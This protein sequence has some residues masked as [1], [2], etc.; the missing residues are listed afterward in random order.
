MSSQVPPLDQVS[1]YPLGLVDDR[2]LT[3][4]KFA[5][6]AGISLVTLRRRIAAHDGPIVTKLSRTSFGHSRA[7]CTGM[8]GRA[9][10]WQ[11]AG[12]VIDA[13][14]SETPQQWLWAGRG[15]STT[16]ILIRV[17][18]VGRGR[19]SA[20]LADGGQVIVRSS[21]QPFLDAA[22]RLIDLGYEPTTVL[23]MR[24]AGSDID[25][26]TAQIGAA[27]KLRV[28]EPDRGRLQF[29]EWEPITR[30]VEALARAKAKRVTGAA[31]DQANE[32]STRPGAAAATQFPSVPVPKPSRPKRSRAARRR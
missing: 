15:I 30:R 25:C 6:I 22:R 5:E 29:V 7:T 31:R 23:V 2:V 24:H 18:P 27:A 8:V 12:G 11:S 16:E 10:L 9:C 26:L 1:P 17:E 32:P 4:S 28:K 14:Q 3:L 13:G 21:R 19:F 20:R